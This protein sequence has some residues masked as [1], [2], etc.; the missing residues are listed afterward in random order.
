MLPVFIQVSQRVVSCEC[1]VLHKIYYFIPLL[2]FQSPC[3]YVF[4]LV[5]CLSHCFVWQILFQMAFPLLLYTAI[6]YPFFLP[7]V[8]EHCILSHSF[9]STLAE[10]FCFP[11]TFVVL[12]E[13]VIMWHLI[14]LLAF[15]WNVNKTLEYRNVTLNKPPN[16]MWLLN[17]YVTL[18]TKCFTVMY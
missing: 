1:Q 5:S 16:F 12:L 10:V 18:F 8:K 3:T 2:E 14:I 4:P 13:T 9:L 11:I 6:S 17:I 7:S 15:L